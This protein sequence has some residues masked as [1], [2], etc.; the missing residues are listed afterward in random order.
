MGFTVSATLRSTRQG[1]PLVSGQGHCT[2]LPRAFFYSQ[3]IC[4]VE[5]HVRSRRWPSYTRRPLLW[6]HV[7]ASK[8][9][10]LG[11]ERGAGFRA[12]AAGQAASRGLQQGRSRERRVISEKPFQRQC[13]WR[14]RWL[15]FYPVHLPDS[16]KG[17]SK[18]RQDLSSRTVMF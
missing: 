9:G 7:W 15:S 6:T 14:L 5:S 13:F 17:P 18:K 1:W 10:V 11:W 4:H 3:S 16:K 12:S 2:T 8:L